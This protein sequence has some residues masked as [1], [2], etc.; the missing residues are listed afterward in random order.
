MKKSAKLK[1]Y[2]FFLV[3]IFNSSFYA[4]SF[5]HINQMAAGYSYS[6]GNSN[7]VDEN[8]HKFYIS[9][10]KADLFFLYSDSK[11]SETFDESYEVGINLYTVNETRIWYPSFSLFMYKD[12]E[13]TGAGT[14]TSLPLKIYRSDHFDLIPEIGASVYFKNFKENF[15]EKGVTCV[16]F[17]IN[18]GYYIN[19][20]SVFTLI[21][22]YKYVKPHSFFSLGA[23]IIYVIGRW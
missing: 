3:V 21:P 17:A 7:P 15:L 19:S 1:G 5:F 22:S 13:N 20:N 8:I 16:E 18:M 10:G 4:Q 12:D 14:A 23:G 9:S 2:I 11:Y 6:A